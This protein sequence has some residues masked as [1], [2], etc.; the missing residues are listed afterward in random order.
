MAYSAKF[1]SLASKLKTD[2]GA[3]DWRLGLAYNGTE[4]NKVTSFPSNWYYS[5][6]SIYDKNKTNTD[7]F[8]PN[9]LDGASPN[10]N[11][12][13][14]IKPNLSFVYTP[15][16]YGDIDDPPSSLDL[17]SEFYTLGCAIVS[18]DNTFPAIVGSRFTAFARNEL[19]LYAGP[20]T[21]DKICSWE[22]RGTFPTDEDRLSPNSAGIDLHP[23][24]QPYKQTPPRRILMFRVYILT[25][26]RAA[27]F[28]EGS[29]NV[30]GDVSQYAINKLKGVL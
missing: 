30:Y 18:E 14:R 16:T 7:R 21:N 1:Q 26:Q 28:D 25:G 24:E 5:G 12:Y 9:L 2:F 17:T 15:T 10:T 11:G 20:T 23:L 4:I 13:R 29:I 22:Y 6:Y 27:A 8:R 19:V 3:Q